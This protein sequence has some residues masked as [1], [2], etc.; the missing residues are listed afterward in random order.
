MDSEQVDTIISLT[1][2]IEALN[3]RIKE[4]K[5]TMKKLKTQLKKENFDLIKLGKINFIEIEED[6]EYDNKYLYL[7][8][9]ENTYYTINGLDKL[10]KEELEHFENF[11]N[12][13][14]YYGYPFYSHPENEASEC[15]LAFGHGSAS[16]T[17]L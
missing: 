1:E 16:I 7:T 15:E 12:D 17:K 11:K 6:E 14:F 9:N 3:I 5:L 8:D 13:Y 10:T 2:Q 4:D